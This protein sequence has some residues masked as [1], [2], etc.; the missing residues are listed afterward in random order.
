MIFS[1]CRHQLL[2][3]NGD[4]LQRELVGLVGVS[5]SALDDL[6][7][8]DRGESWLLTVRKIYPIASRLASFIVSSGSLSST[9]TDGYLEV[10]IL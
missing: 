9:Y 6:C 3:E 1:H 5:N 8:P 4:S 7:F 10:S 2:P